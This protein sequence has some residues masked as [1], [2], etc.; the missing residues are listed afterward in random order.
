MATTIGGVSAGSSSTSVDGDGEGRR[1][2]LPAPNGS[3]VGQASRRTAV[4]ARSFIRYATAAAATAV[5]ITIQ[6]NRRRIMPPEPGYL[7]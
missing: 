3:S 2:E 6:N 4:R 7:P 5:S 1:A